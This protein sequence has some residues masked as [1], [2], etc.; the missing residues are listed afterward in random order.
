MNKLEWSLVCPVKDEVDLIPRTLP[1]FYSV[2]PS[3]VVLCSDK[4]S[5]ESIKKVVW[6]IASLFDAEDKTRILEV[7]RN[8]EYAFHQAWVRRKGFLEATYERILTG[9]IDLIINKNVLKAI[10]LVGKGN[11]GLVSLSKFS[12]PTNSSDFWRLVV[13]TFLRKAVHGMLDPLIATTTFS[14]LYALW[15]PYWLDSEPEEEIKKL[16]NP[17]QRL[18]GEHVEAIADVTGEDTF[19]RDKMKDRYSCIYLRDIGAIDLR[20]GLENVPYCQYMKG[21]YFA[22]SKRPLLISL[23]RAILRAQPYY[24]VGH[25][26][27]LEE[28]K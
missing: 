10:R 26:H 22:N 9:D 1:S 24:L 5:P 21:K 4:P 11:T 25:L 8:P 3:E 13:T 18:R 23:G 28:Y 7:E 14:G 16:V 19:L 12:Y 17:K 15:R 20:K 2:K 27:A 6:K